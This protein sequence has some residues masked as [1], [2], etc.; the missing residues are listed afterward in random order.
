[1]GVRVNMSRKLVV[2][3]IFA[4]FSLVILFI[5]LYKQGIMATGIVIE[6]DKVSLRFSKESY[7]L[8][9]I[10][11]KGGGGKIEFKD[12][13]LWRIVLLD[14]E[15]AKESVG[16][17]VFKELKSS[18]GVWTR[19]FQIVEF[20]GGKLLKLFWRND[21]YMEVEVDVML[22]EGSCFSIWN[23][24]VRNYSS[25]Y[26]IWYVDFPILVVKP[27]EGV[28][29]DNFLAMP[30]NGGVLI[31][32]PFDNINWDVQPW[33]EVRPDL[34]RASWIDTRGSYPGNYNAQFVALYSRSGVGL[35]FSSLDGEMYSKRFLFAGDGEALSMSIRN[36]PKDMLTPGLCYI[37]PYE[38][39]IGIFHGDWMDVADI[40]KEWAI[41]QV[42]CRKGPMYMWRDLSKPVYDVDLT[43]IAVYR[44]SLSAPIH[45]SQIREN[46]L[47]MMEFFNKYAGNSTVNMGVHW[48]G[49]SKYLDVVNENSG[50]PNYLP[51][52]ENFTRLISELKSTGVFYND[53]YLTS[54]GAD[55]NTPYKDDDKYV[56]EDYEEY[57]C[58]N[59]L[60]KP[61]TRFTPH[62][63][64]MDLSQRGWQDIVI[65]VSCE[66]L[67]RC[68]LD[69]IYYDWYPKY[70]L[71]FKHHKGGGNYFAVGYRETIQRIKDEAR[72]INPDFYCCPEGKSEIEIGVFDA[73]LMEWFHSDSNGV[74][75]PFAD[76][77]KPIPLISYIY[78]E[79]IAMVGGI[80]VKNKDFTGFQNPDEFRLVSAIIWAWGNKPLYPFV[81]GRKSRKYV[82]IQ[83]KNGT[84]ETVWEENL[85]YLANLV[86]MYK[87]GKEALF[88]GKMLRPP[89]L[90][91]TSIAKV[92]L[93]GKIKTVPTVIVG[94]FALPPNETVIYIPATNWGNTDETI[95]GIDFS[96]C[97]WLDSPF[98]LTIIRSNSTEAIGEFSANTTHIPVHIT[99]KKGEAI[100][101]VIRKITEKS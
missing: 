42:W 89:K 46:L 26:A 4:I 12:S 13:L 78:H 66:T 37:V 14:V 39:K 43:L 24:T 61:Y 69:G 90:E 101:L 71:D 74:I 86:R 59:P 5:V 79:Y 34:W 72:K 55:M 49:W 64:W 25:R 100:F 47:A 54:H 60:G 28:K 68:Q 63:V 73:M 32:N 3:T 20:D 75:H 44:V 85:K 7:S 2:A 36:Y 70:R 30:L 65:E 94:A 45:Y 82:F 9:V 18:D 52:Q 56:W 19:S 62:S 97:K 6:N 77:G 93:G 87:I 67:R 96:K 21:G 76:I 27:I 22:L 51:P 88:Y 10:V 29:E 48:I 35:Y 80:R 99:I 57:A 91:G 23:I 83:W 8:V 84:L 41:K 95:T 38:F 50:F 1:M 31:Q 17:D 40:Y 58:Y 81:D 16:K 98:Q 53:V 11:D 92:N 33:E 15:K